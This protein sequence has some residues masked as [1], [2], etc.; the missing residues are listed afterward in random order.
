MPP[1][2]KMIVKEMFDTVNKQ[3]EQAKYAEK[4][5]IPLGNY[6]HLRVVMIE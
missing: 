5:N 2:H 6:S 3:V 4:Y 1:E